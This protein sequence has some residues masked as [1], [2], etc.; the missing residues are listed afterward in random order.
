MMLLLVHLAEGLADLLREGV[1][2]AV[3]VSDTFPLDD[4]Y[5]FHGDGDLVETLYVD[6]LAHLGLHLL[7]GSNISPLIK[8]MADIIHNGIF[9]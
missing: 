9:K 3:G 4:L 7:A 2:D 6:V 1:R 8:A 5:L